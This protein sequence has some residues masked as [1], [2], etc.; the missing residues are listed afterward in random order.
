M[1]SAVRSVLHGA[2]LGLLLSAP[3]AAAPRLVED[4][5]KGP[6][7]EYA[8]AY[9]GVASNGIFYHGGSDPAH[10][11]ELWKSDG[12]A[13]GTGRV[14]DVCPGRC[15]AN[16]S[17]LGIFDGWVYFLADDGVSG[18]E[19]WRTNGVPGSERRVRDIC[20][21]PCGSDGISRMAELGDAIFFLASDGVTES[22]W[23]TRGSRRSTVRAVDLCP[24][25]PPGQ[26]PNCVWSGFQQ[27]GGVLLFTKVD[28]SGRRLDL[29]RTD[30]TQAG[31]SI[32]RADIPS[33]SAGLTRFSGG[34][35]YF[36]AGEAVWRTDGT[37]AGT[38]RLK[39]YDEIL[40][41]PEHPSQHPIG[42]DFWNGAFYFL[43]N[44][45]ELIRSDGTREGTRPIH[46]FQQPTSGP[47][48]L[49][50]GLLV[51]TGPS[52]QQQQLW[53]NLGEPGTTGKL[54]DFSTEGYIGQ[55]E[56][57]GEDR[58]LFLV[59]LNAGDFDLWVTDGTPEGT[60]N[61]GVEGL[62]DPYALLP[63]GD[64]VYWVNG[65]NT[66]RP[67]GLWRSDGTQAGTFEVRDLH[68]G[69]GSAGPPA[70]SVLNDRLVF[71]ARTGPETAPL[72]ISDGTAAGTRVISNA[73][74]WATTFARVG[75][76]LFFP[77]GTM[78][79]YP[80]WTDI[81]QQKG[82]WKTDGAAAGTRVVDPDRFGIG[83]LWS[84]GN[85]ILFPA[86]LEVSPHGVRDV[87]LFRA[88]AVRQGAPLVKNID[89]YTID[90]SFHHICVGES[91]NPGPAVAV[92]GRLLFA[93]RD[94]VSGTELWSSDGTR[95]GTRLVRDV[96][97]KT[98]VGDSG[99]CELVNLPPRERIG[100][101]SDPRDFVAFRNGALFTADDG[102]TGRELW[103]TDG[104]R[105][106]TRR[107]AD[108]RPGPE[109]SNPHDLT[110]F[111]GEVYFVASG[112]LAGEAL[113]R[114]DGTT[115]RT[116]PVRNLALG[117]LP[118]WAKSLTAVGGR[119]FF[120]VYNESTG[121]ELWSSRGT[122]ETTRMVEDVRPG[123]P[124][125]YPQMLTNAGGVLVYA[126]DDGETGL[127][128]WR[129]DGTAA[130]TRRLG[131]VFPGLNASSPGPF[132]KVGTVVL[133]GAYEDVHGRELW[134]IPMA[135]V[136]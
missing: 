78:T 113:W 69:P 107:V 41:H 59:G 10:G 48:A 92:G 51:T 22:L 36:W 16:P 77:A 44:G 84:L 30:G 9:G 119:L 110:V 90:S 127:E 43:M 57:V 125:S 5:H 102:T 15:N 131:D 47:L 33:I 19:L 34:I 74:Q 29:W 97:P 136:R 105:T 80:D 42:Y 112:Q 117:S 60:R 66:Y 58:A 115:Q 73:A 96:N 6:A 76:Q 114:T 135:D 93:A 14:T 88:D 79:S 13:A 89:P 4:L 81:F 18:V 1:I 2:L 71:S 32:V 7:D 55:L 103:W 95:Q 39:G 64:L 50:G 111:R 37:A 23:R 116:V 25:K 28:P 35:A 91:S 20:P 11:A 120:A 54:A 49:D 130:G 124:G 86:V 101:G 8:Y 121:A 63:A 24:V 118:S 38:V 52:L 94:G 40:V 82:L 17:V 83:P 53:V 109:G 85:Q 68:A 99:D 61:T 70:Q 128:P 31:T 27:I 75:N 129:S 98:V 62:S 133:T 65:V 45:G 21:G 106:G 3:A 126:A 108:L 87:E 122:A 26:G 123:A 104:T 67:E 72:F 100:L 12:T 56:R 134:A 132:S 46:I